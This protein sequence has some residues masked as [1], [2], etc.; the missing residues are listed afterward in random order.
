MALIKEITFYKVI[1]YN[2]KVGL[3][4][5]VTTVF[6]LMRHATKAIFTNSLNLSISRTI[7]SVRI[8]WPDWTF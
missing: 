1:Q 3:A 6:A 7:K 5:E 2:P 8:M 4:F